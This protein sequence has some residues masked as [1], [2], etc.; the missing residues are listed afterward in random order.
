M[1]RK[2][3]LYINDI[4]KSI[5]LIIDFTDN[6]DFNDF[7]NDEKTQLAV[8]KCLETIGEAVKQ[9]PESILRKYTDIPWKD[10]AGM[11][12][13]LVHFYFGVDLEIVWETVKTEIPPLLPLFEKMKL[14][15]SGE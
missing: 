12:D 2:I 4:L 5:K 14:E 7:A 3:S 1:K 8:I 9:I 15:L 10:I 13:R 11:R 6:L